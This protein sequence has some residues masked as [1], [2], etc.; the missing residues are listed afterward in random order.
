MSPLVAPNGHGAMSD[1]SPLSVAKR[2]SDLGAVRSAFDPGCVKTPTL[3]LRVEFLS[4]FRRCGNRL[5][6]D[7]S[8]EKTIEKT[9]LRVLGSSE[10]SH[11]LDPQLT[12][13]L[14]GYLNQEDRS[15]SAPNAPVSVLG[16]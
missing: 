9:I 11:S 7:F 8:C 10:F 12:L 16:R 13:G 15:A 14:V 6:R 4:Q 5:H 3:N 2:K 1:L